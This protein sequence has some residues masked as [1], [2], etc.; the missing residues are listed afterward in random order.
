MASPGQQHQDVGATVELWLV[1]AE[2]AFVGASP[3]P[4]LSSA[5]LALARRTADGDGARTEDVQ[6]SGG[7]HGETLGVRLVARPAP[8]GV[9]AVASLALAASQ[10]DGT[11]SRFDVVMQATHDAVW[12]WNAVSDQSWWNRQQYTMLGYDPESTVPSYEAWIS[13]I[14][15][16]DRERIERY[17]R[18]S[19]ASGATEWQ[20]EYRFT[21]GDGGGVHVALERGCIERDEQGRL[22][23]IAGVMNDFVHSGLAYRAGRAETAVY[24]IA[25]EADFGDAS[26]REQAHSF[27]VWLATYRHGPLSPAELAERT[28]L[29]R[30]S[31]E[32]ALRELTASGRASRDDVSGRYSSDHFEVPFG[33]EHG[34]E[35]AVLDHYQALVSAIGMKLGLGREAAHLKDAVGGSTWSLDVWPGH[36]H[37]AEAKGTLARLRTSVEELRIRIDAFNAGHERPEP[38]ERVVVYLGQYLRQNEESEHERD[39]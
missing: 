22:A 33:T 6:L 26:S 14:H 2:G 35:A 11:L 5:I 31:V 37:E 7:D 10:P 32:S 27:I 16:D 25:A 39:E 4:A 17:L 36:P 34:W 21:R 3:P 19:V 9:V 20:C 24:R 18:E 29:G 38:K 28:G 12:D 13:R 15:P 30:E 1:D 8:G 23:R